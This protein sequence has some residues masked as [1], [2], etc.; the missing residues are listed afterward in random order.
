MILWFFTNENSTFISNCL[1]WL[2]TKSKLF[3][4]YLLTRERGK[5][6]HLCLYCFR[7]HIFQDGGTKA[8]TIPISC[9]LTVLCTHVQ[10]TFFCPFFTTL[11]H[12]IVLRCLPEKLVYII[13]HLHVMMYCIVYGIKALVY[14][15]YCEK[16][17]CCSP[18]VN[19]IKVSWRH[20]QR[21]VWLY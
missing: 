21:G 5:K 18:T 2:L 12:K 20:L 15:S 9:H 8:H 3:Q 4:S 19:E 17:Y 16:S 7:S 11:L 13:H 6:F 1:L 10:N 14:V